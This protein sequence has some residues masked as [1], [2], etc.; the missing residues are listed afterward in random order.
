MDPSL[1][2]HEYQHRTVLDT[3]QQQVA[4]VYAKALIGV[5]EKAGVSDQVLADYAT[6]VDAVDSLLPR[7][8]VFVFGGI[9]R[10]DML[11]VLDRTFGG[12]VHPLLL[13]FLKVLAEHNRLNCL[14]V[15]YMASTELLDKL[16]S[17]IRVKVTTATPLPDSKAEEL[18]V[19]LRRATGA[20]PVLISKVDSKVIGGLI[21]Q[22][23]DTVYD[24][25][26]MAQLEHMRTRLIDRSTHEIERRRDRVGS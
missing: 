8:A 23:G 2:E 16:R 12:R 10:D 13:N 9:P 22:V 5:T 26:V 3:D 21:V 15:I 6:V 11:G 7:A 18:K 4:D 25:S 20:E 19:I 1:H 14:R 17:R 24:G